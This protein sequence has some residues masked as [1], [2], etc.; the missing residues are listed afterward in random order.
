MIGMKGHPIEVGDKDRVV[1]VH[2][3]VTQRGGAERVVL[4]L[5][6]S[7]PDA[8]LVTSTWNRSS[9]FEEFAD[10]PIE[11]L[12]IDKVPSFRRDPRL[13]L[14]FLARAFSRHVIKDADL[15]ICSSS[16]WSHRVRSS[17]PRMVYC[18]N[19]ARWLYQPDDYFATT[20]A[21]LR[22]RFAHC[23]DRL[24]RSDAAAAHSAAAYVTTSTTVADR[25][26]SAY[27]I[28]P[29]IIP[30]PRGLTPEGPLDPIAGLMPGFLLTVSR[31]RGYKHTDRVVAAVESMPGQ[32]LVVVG[33]GPAEWESDTVS[34][35]RSVSDAGLRCSTSTPLDWSRPLMRTSGSPPSRRRRAALRPSRFAPAAIWTPR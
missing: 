8:R 21:W 27:G 13:A 12:W 22:A 25:I 10:F 3:Y 35:L 11:T 2:D 17:A 19:P 1:I 30:P 29:A 7:F 33:G 18:Y 5:L 23:S 14:P 26:E 6:R 24:R 34:V 4:E 31:T 20:P 9:T 32:R 16:G 15:V 28:T